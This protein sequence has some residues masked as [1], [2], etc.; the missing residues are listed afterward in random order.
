MLDTLH[1]GSH[2]G[3]QPSVQASKFIA[4]TDITS[5]RKVPSSKSDSLTSAPIRKCHEVC[6]RGDG[7]KGV[8]KFRFQIFVSWQIQATRIK[9][10]VKK[11]AVEDRTKMNI[12][13]WQFDLVKICQALIPQATSFTWR[14]F[15]QNTLSIQWRKDQI[16]PIP[17]HN[18]A[19]HDVASP[20]VPPQFQHVGFCWE[21]RLQESPRRCQP[22]YIVHYSQLMET[23]KVLQVRHVFHWTWQLNPIYLRPENPEFAALR[24]RHPGWANLSSAVHRSLSR[25]L[26]RFCNASFLKQK[27]RWVR[28]WRPGIPI[29]RAFNKATLQP[30]VL[31]NAQFQAFFKPVNTMFVT[32]S[33]NPQGGGFVFKQSCLSGL[34]SRWASG[35]ATEL[36]RSIY[37]LSWSIM[38][39]VDQGWGVLKMINANQLLTM[40]MFNAQMSWLVSEL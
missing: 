39:A 28:F 5:K 22:H 30:I 9:S 19:R 17:L 7:K 35:N 31:L 38:F 37:A 1:P 15:D 29:Q 25:C 14:N 3:F 24:P 16:I 34:P 33:S 18:N 2:A 40:I 32:R 12:K 20:A 10:G 13:G 26:A 27:R 11:V 36:V 6:P 21:E 23:K 4:S 8:P